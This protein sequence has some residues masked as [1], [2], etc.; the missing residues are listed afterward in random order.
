MTNLKTKPNLDLNK[1]ND[2]NK[3]NKKINLNF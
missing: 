1:L 2:L 3:K